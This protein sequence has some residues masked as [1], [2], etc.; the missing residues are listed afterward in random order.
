MA[1]GRDTLVVYY[2]G[3]GDYNQRVGDQV[4]TTSGGDLYLQREVQAAAS[5]LRPKVT[6]IFSDACSVLITGF[7]AA[8]DSQS[9]PTG[10]S[11]VRFLVLRLA[12]GSRADQR[13][14]ERSNCRM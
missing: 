9:L 10:R 12:A 3:H 11:P 13:D 6:V 8:P 1:A 2:S 14:D 4:M 5:Q 7:P